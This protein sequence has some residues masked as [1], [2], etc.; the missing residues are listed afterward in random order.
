MGRTTR[1]M[2]RVDGNTGVERQDHNDLIE[3][4]RC[5]LQQLNALDD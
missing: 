5:S 3:S 4:D 1:G 2:E